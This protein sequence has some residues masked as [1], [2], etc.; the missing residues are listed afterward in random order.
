MDS[1]NGLL[2]VKCQA[3]A[4]TNAELMSIDLI[5]KNFSSSGEQPEHRKL[6]HEL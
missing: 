2:P 1:D 5:H 4:W 6:A 3:I